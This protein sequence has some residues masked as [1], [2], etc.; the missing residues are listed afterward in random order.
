MTT[1]IIA[2]IVFL[3]LGLYLLC[4]GNAD[5]SVDSVVS[6]IASVPCFAIALILLIVI[7]YNLQY[8]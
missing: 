1:I 2:F 7:L 3:V 5:D 4:S 8:L 6:I